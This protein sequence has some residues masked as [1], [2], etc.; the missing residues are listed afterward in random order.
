MKRAFFFTALW[1][2]PILI[3]P[4]QS[5]EQLEISGRILG[6]TS[7][8]ITIHSTRALR[9]GEVRIHRSTRPISGS[10]MNPI[11]YP[12]TTRVLAAENS[13][14][15]FIDDMVAQNV[16]YYYLASVA[17][18][19]EGELFSNVFS[20]TLSALDLP[21]L[22]KPEILI[23]K[24]H[25]ILEVREAGRPVKKYPVI[26]GR[27]PVS[28]KLH[29]DFATTPEGAYRITHRKSNSVFHRALDIDYPNALD[30][31]RYEFLRSKGKVPSGKG[32]GGEIQVH[33][34]LRNW[35]L[36]RNWT[37]GCIALRNADIEEL[38]GRP[39]IGVG[40]PV[41]LVGQEV[42]RADLDG[43]AKNRTTADI[44]LLQERLRQ[45]G[46]YQGPVD[47]IMG[48]QT[49]IALGRF[50]LVSGYPVTCDLDVRTFQSL[51]KSP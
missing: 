17:G 22:K 16:T 25:Y 36:E 39:E 37:W 13:P 10:D 2:V 11:R 33:G 51:M 29:Q 28:R 40:T 46:H 21:A 48:R 41:Y 42:T 1:L 8:E 18:G 45:T 38:F 50:Q 12:V 35:A 43:K 34:Q 9:D 30:R 14:F 15:K 26:L 4:A 31:I 7:V 19:N 44:R 6:Q 23:D 3:S 32:I 24:I 49:R 27:D 20:L 5:Q 47:G